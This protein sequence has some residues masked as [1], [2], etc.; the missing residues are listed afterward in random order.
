[1][2]SIQELTSDGSKDSLQGR[3]DLKQNGHTCRRMQK[4]Q[5]PGHLM[6]LS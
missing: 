5:L 2:S 4:L 1:M 6:L 3:Q